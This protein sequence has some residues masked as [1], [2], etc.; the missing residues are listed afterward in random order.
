MTS[1]AHTTLAVYALH[2]T[3]VPPPSALSAVML[4]LVDHRDGYTDNVLHVT[5]RVRPDGFLEHELVTPQQGGKERLRAL[6]LAVA[7]EDPI[8]NAFEVITRDEVHRAGLVYDVLARET[9]ALDGRSRTVT[10]AGEDFDIATGKSL[11]GQITQILLDD[12]DRIQAARSTRPS[13][14]LVH[15]L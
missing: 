1:Q 14:R 7:V 5:V 3:D 12:N 4:A 15:S 6:A 8:V 13:L 11:F 2:S 10:I 9:T